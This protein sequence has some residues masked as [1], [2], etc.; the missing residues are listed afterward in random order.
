MKNHTNLTIKMVGKVFECFN[1]KISIFKSLKNIKLFFLV[2]K[3]NVKIYKI[4]KKLR[5]RKNI[6][7]LST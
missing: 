3:K 1:P 2:K 6:S 5:L 7:F 4:T